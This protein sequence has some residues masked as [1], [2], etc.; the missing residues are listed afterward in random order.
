MAI[1]NFKF[2]SPGVYIQ[3]IDKSKLPTLPEAVGPVVIGRTVR[4]PVMR[5]VKVNSYAEFVELFGEPS[6]GNQAGDV[7]R[8]GNYLA[9]TYGA[10]AAQAY[11]KNSNPVTF[12][13]LG[14]YEHPNRT[15]AGR[16]GWYKQSAYGLFVAPINK[17]ADDIYTM[18]ATA[19]LAAIFY[20]NTTDSTKFG[21]SGK[22]LSGSADL[23]NRHATWIRADGANLQF[24]TIVGGTSASVNYD[25]NSKKYIRSVLNTNPVMTNDEVVTEE[26]NYF[27]GETFKTW[28][29]ENS[30]NNISNNNYN[31]YD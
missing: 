5:P 14:G 2:V 18:N 27:L 10:Y 31:F 20:A 6:P 4:G 17:S 16:A 21:L 23:V 1:S 26:K 25:E 30:N 12:V 28:V 29:L 22:Q 15:S 13:R 24:R 11:L 3:E 9:P 8:E 19:S 7:W